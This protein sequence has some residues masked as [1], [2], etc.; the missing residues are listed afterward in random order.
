MPADT[1]Q[2]KRAVIE[3]PLRSLGYKKITGLDALK[4]LADGGAYNVEA[5]FALIIAEVQDVGWRDDGVD[6]TGTD[7][8]KLVKDVPFWYTGPLAAIKFLELAAGAVLHVTF[9]D[10]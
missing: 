5:K 7:R 4:G 10:E 9:Y 6:P 1:A 3:M 2:V 8:M